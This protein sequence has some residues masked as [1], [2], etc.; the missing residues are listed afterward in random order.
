[1]NSSGPNSRPPTPEVLAALKELQAEYGRV[2]PVLV[3]KLADALA[4][5]RRAPSDADALEAVRAQAHKLRGTAG[6][7]GFPGV[8]DAAVRMEDTACRLQKGAEPPS[9]EAWEELERAMADMTAE[10]RR[11]A[12]EAQQQ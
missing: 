7:Y 4:R 8:G 1:M 11:A 5:A 12:E 3:G 10:A 9:E 6:S 2:L